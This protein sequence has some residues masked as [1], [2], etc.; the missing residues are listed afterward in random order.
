MARFGNINQQ[1]ADSPNASAVPEVLGLVPTWSFLRHHTFQQNKNKLQENGC[2]ICNDTATKSMWLGCG[3]KNK[4]TGNED[5]GCIN[6]ALVFIIRGQIIWPRFHSTAQNLERKKKW[7]QAEQNEL[8]HIIFLNRKR[9][10][11]SNEW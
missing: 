3:H 1:T 8:S 7:R 4:L 5:C 6:G 9:E 10:V 2:C 11:K